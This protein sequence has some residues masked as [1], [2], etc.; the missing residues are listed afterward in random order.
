MVTFGA[1]LM[2]RSALGPAPYDV[3]FV[4]LKETTPLTLGM[5]AFLVQVLI[6]IG[7]SIARKNPRFLF[8]FSSLALGG[9]ALDFW[10]LFALANFQPT[11]LWQRLLI[12]PVG[13][14]ILT[15]GL[16]IISTTKLAA[17]SFDELMYLLMDWFDTKRVF[18]VRFGI[19]MSGVVLGVIVGFIG[20]IGFGQ[21]T[22]A[23]LAIV[24]VLPV[25]LG[26]QYRML[27]RLGFK[28]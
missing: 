2:I 1:L 21:V 17:V 16:A 4:H 14:Y 12:Y 28:R 20:G 8:S 24:F 27:E 11:L 19:E 3:L 9:A 5:S 6:I 15:L 26:W 18:W 23:T 10:D 25:F 13:I 22:V 7:V